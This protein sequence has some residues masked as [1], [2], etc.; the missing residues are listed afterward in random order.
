[1]K[2]LLKEIRANCYSLTNE[3]NGIDNNVYLSRE[4][5]ENYLED[6]YVRQLYNAPLLPGVVSPVLGLP[7]IHTGYG[8]PIG[9]VMA[10]DY[11]DG[12]VCSQGQWVWI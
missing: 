4:L 11:E 7:D 1:M 12:V 10:T 6:E 5:Y 8:L 9:G 2:E 3:Q